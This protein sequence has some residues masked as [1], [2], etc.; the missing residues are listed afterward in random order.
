MMDA[1]RFERLAYDPDAI[2]PELTDT[3][4]LLRTLSDL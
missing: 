1:A 4:L 2:L 3:G